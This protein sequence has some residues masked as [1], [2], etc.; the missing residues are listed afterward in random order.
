ML[1]GIVALLF[2]LAVLA[3]KASAMPAPVRRLVLHVLRRGEPTAH[4]FVVAAAR[5]CGAPL[6]WALPAATGRTSSREAALALAW[7]LRILA[8]ALRDLPRRGFAAR[9]ARLQWRIEQQRAACSAGLA[10][11]GPIA[12]DT[13]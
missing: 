8:V 4:S 11:N 2:A 9:M 1:K 12:C 5:E 3:E 6:Q 7:W 10:S 13:S